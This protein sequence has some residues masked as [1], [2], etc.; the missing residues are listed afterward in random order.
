LTFSR[1]ANPL[2]LALSVELQYDVTTNFLLIGSS[3]ALVIAVFLLL[4]VF[5]EIAQ[6]Q[7]GEAD[8]GS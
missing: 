1:K 5:E 3:A 7:F 4:P 6:A 8:H 2:R